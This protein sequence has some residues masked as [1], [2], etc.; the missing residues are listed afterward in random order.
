MA[1]IKTENLTKSYGK[2]RGIINLN[3][4]VNEGEFFGF[5]GPNGAGKS[6]TIRTLLG[7]ISPTSGK[8]EIFGKDISS[9][10]TEILSDIG[11]MPSE[12]VFYNRMKVK[13]VIE[14]SAKMRK[15]NCSAESEKLCE[16]L[17]LDT[18]KRI[19]ELSLGNRKKVS[20]VC[21]VQHKPRLCILD[22][23][24][25][26]LDPLMQKEFFDIL[27][28]LNSEGTTI[29]L[30]S[31]VLSEIQKNCSRTAIIK[32]GRII[33]TDSVENLSRTNA[34]RVTIHGINSLPEN[35]NAKSVEKTSDYIS[36][37]YSDDIKKLLE[38]ASRLPVNDITITEPSLEE[39]FM[40]YYEK[41]GAEI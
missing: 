15:K 30:S 6:T 29:F 3:L 11:Y 28:E 22:E 24:T 27:K 17:A 26:G 41:D 1:I 25:S 8:A 39:I 5:I 10:K 31:H 13:E 40:H 38:T 33:A 4:K 12:A 14:F 18:G 7:L 20:I 36:F 32:D 16:R 37:L 2:S 19:E 34:K 23:P 35:L 9:H 21:A